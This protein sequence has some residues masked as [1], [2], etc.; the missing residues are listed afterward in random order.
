MFLMNKTRQYM[1]VVW[2]N[3]FLSALVVVIF[4]F[5]IRSYLNW[6]GGGGVNSNHATI[7]KTIQANYP[8]YKNFKQEVALA[9]FTGLAE[10][11]GSYVPFTGWR[12]E[13]YENRAV[14]V[15]PRWRTRL[16]LGHAEQR[17]VWFLGGSTMWGIGATNETTIPSFFSTMTG[18]RVWNFGEIA[19]T[20][21]QELIQLQMMLANGY[22]PKAVIFYDGVNES[23]YCNANVQS[24]PTHAQFDA[25]LQYVSH[26]RELEQ[27]LEEAQSKPRRID[28]LDLMAQPFQFIFSPY[29]DL[30]RRATDKR[31]IGAKPAKPDRRSLSTGTPFSQFRRRQFYKV[32]GDNPERAKA[33]AAMT[34]ETWL[35][36]YDLLRSR[37]I[38]SY[39]FLQ[40]SSHIKPESYHLDYL[41]YE[42][43]QRIANERDSF[44]K[45][46]NETKRI[47]HTR[48]GIHNACGSFY[49][50]SEILVGFREP[51]FIDEV[52]ISPN[53]NAFIAKKMSEIVRLD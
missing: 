9:I 45:R 4:S 5:T 29:Q 24:L 15:E 10:S 47:W 44:V 31:S 14:I 28:A 46:Y 25:Y 53:G 23:F 41:L 39:F 17:S 49:D 48:C 8:N 36:A 13:P 16:S 22:T 2:W 7:R 30:W 40:P 18:E 12:R 1:R 51:V 26:Y 6:G 33:A 27:K 19:Y 11:R 52:H 34:V 32:C 37:G 50:L 3:A 20:S 35:L 42:N 38:P 21:F 43:K